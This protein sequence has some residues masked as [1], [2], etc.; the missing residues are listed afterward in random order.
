MKRLFFVV[1][2]N[3]YMGV[4]SAQD[5]LEYYSL[6]NQA[7]YF[8][9]KG[10]YLASDSIFSIA[11]RKFKGHKHDFL[12]AGIIS[13]HLRDTLKCVT[14]LSKSIQSGLTLEQIENNKEIQTLFERRLIDKVKEDYPSNRESYIANLDQRELRFYKKIERRDQ[15]YRG[16]NGGGYKQHFSKVVRLDSGDFKM[17]KTRILKRGWPYL[18]DDGA[19]EKT[20]NILTQAI[21]HF[22]PGQKDF[23]LPYLKQAVLSGFAYPEQYSALADRIQLDLLKP[24]IYGSTYYVLSDG[25]LRVYPINTT[26]INEINGRRR[27]IGVPTFEYCI[28]KYGATYDPNFTME[29]LKEA[30]GIKK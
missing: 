10:Q 23:F 21:N 1:V 29:Q 13:A 12:S 19:V 5:Y 9:K 18:G 25:I 24:Q 22:N 7:S 11:F 14:L 3:I 15:R 4:C 2:L 28:E 30:I 20:L 17:V 16:K 27:E 6:V 8:G 26:S